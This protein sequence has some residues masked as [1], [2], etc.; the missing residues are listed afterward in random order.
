MVVKILKWIFVLFRDSRVG[1]DRRDRLVRRE[2]VFLV[3]K[4]RKVI[5]RKVVG[6]D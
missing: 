4:E 3:L 1:L 5:P 2:L 6:I